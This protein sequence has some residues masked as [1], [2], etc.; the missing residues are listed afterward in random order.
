MQS[1]LTAPLPSGSHNGAGPGCMQMGGG[2][3]RVQQSVCVFVHACRLP[4]CTHTH[5][6]THTHTETNTPHR[7]MDC[8]EVR[9][10]LYEGGIS[11]VWRAVVGWLG[12]GCGWVVQQMGALL[13][14]GDPATQLI[15]DAS[16]LF[17]NLLTPTPWPPPR[18]L[19]KIGFHSGTMVAIKAYTP[20]T[21]TPPQHT[22]EHT[23]QGF[24]FF[25]FS[26]NSPP[27][28]F[29]DKHSGITVAIKAYKRPALN[30]MERH[31][32]GGARA[33]RRACACMHGACVCVCVWCARLHVCVLFCVPVE[34]QEE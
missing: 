22:H 12:L 30:A 14:G 5:T 9:A 1:A 33:G 27:L 21:H 17:L 13:P 8:F 29:Q 3:A 20:P 15:T 6:H 11:T 31:Q 16:S 4:T 34:C 19:S 18:L 2:G 26:T 28:R 7:S 32:V 24:L 25:P 23:V 10:K